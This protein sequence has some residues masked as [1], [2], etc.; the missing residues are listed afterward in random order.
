MAHP[1]NHV[2]TCPL[3]CPLQIIFV[4]VYLLSGSPAHEQITPAPDPSCPDPQC[5]PESLCVS[6][7]RTSRPLSALALPGFGYMPGFFSNAQLASPRYITLEDQSDMTCS[8]KIARYNS[9]PALTH[10]QPASQHSLSAASDDAGKAC[11]ASALARGQSVPTMIR[12]FTQAH[13]LSSESVLSPQSPLSAHSLQSCQS[14]VFSSRPTAAA[15]VDLLSPYWRSP[16]GSVLQQRT[17]AT[18]SVDSEQAQLHSDS[19]PMLGA[20]APV[21][22]RLQSTTS[23]VVAQ[24]LDTMPG[25]FSQ[26]DAPDKG[27]PESP[28]NVPDAA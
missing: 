2:L 27:L 21:A 14:T 1:A 16:A 22:F 9:V 28:H 18:L 23:D 12:P 26:T 19:V 7:R 15:D 10:L 13:S 6:Q 24:L 8:P 5:D 20:F 11:I 3:V 25:F 17:A 4:G